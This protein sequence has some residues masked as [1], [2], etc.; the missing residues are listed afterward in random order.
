MSSAAA[1]MLSV[2]EKPKLEADVFNIPHF[3]QMD[4][5]SRKEA[6][7]ASRM[8]DAMENCFLSL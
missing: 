3:K 8:F 4:K 2:K 6:I 5:R 1:A 7:F